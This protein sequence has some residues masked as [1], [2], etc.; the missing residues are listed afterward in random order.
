MLEV[1]GLTKT[2]GNITAVDGVDMQVAQG[3]IHGLIG[4]NG[5]GKSTTMNLI[6]GTYRPTSGQ[7][8]LNGAAIGGL[9]AFRVARMGVV[10][11]FQLTRVYGQLSLLEAVRIGA[12]AG[13]GAPWNP[14]LWRPFRRDH[15]AT[16][17]ARDALHRLGLGPHADRNAGS[18]PSGMRRILSIATALAASPR[19]LLLDEPLAGLNASEKAEVADRILQLRQDG[20]TILLVEHDV[21]SIMRLCDW[22]T[23]INFGKVIATGTPDEIGRNEAVIAAYLGDRRHAHAAG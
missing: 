7:V 13:T 11:T 3:S 19:V 16:E 1:R 2:F 14:R 23:V 20:L 6:S 22:I 10:R 18:L 17:A 21:R 15:P 8:L 4:P 5:S 12:L 9:P